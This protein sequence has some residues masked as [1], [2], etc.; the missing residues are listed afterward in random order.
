M[1]DSG[2]WDR[3]GPD[4]PPAG[5]PDQPRRSQPGWDEPGRQQPPGQPSGWEQPGW[6]QP[7][8]AGAPPGRPWEP[9]DTAPK[10]GT[11]PLRPLGI[12]ELLDGSLQA[13]RRNPRPMLLLPA[14]VGAVYGLATG[15]VLA[16]AAPTLFQGGLFDSGSGQLTEADASRL[17]LAVLGLL[18]VVILF[19]LA[20]L[21][22]TAV[23]T[24]VVAR[25]ALGDRTTA[26][27][28]WRFSRGRV[29]PLVGL[30]IVLGVAAAV[31]FSVGIALLVAL[32]VAIA[33][34]TT[35]AARVVLFVL[36]VLVALAAVVLFALVYVGRLGL[37]SVVL[38]LDG[39]FPDATGRP[40]GVFAAIAR[41]WRLTRGHLWRT[42]GV[43]LLVQLIAGVAAQLV[44]TPLSLLG[45]PLGLSDTAAQVGLP[46]LSAL[47]S[48]VG[49]VVALP[50]TA[51]GTTLTYLD[52]R[53]RREGLDLELALAADAAR[54]LQR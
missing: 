43:L 3:P 21:A 34:L 40:L 11:I 41:T 53:M 52:L 23:L 6:G 14:V 12:G 44:Q 31:A 32:G 16:V 37:A 1:S 24:V 45:G 50:F 15:I 49:L 5:G 17:G 51:A 9:A 4:G 2:G 27:E 54:G 38:V 20:T 48:V 18:P 39:R 7:G 29:L 46:I 33:E 25:S 19:G 26:G 13:I 22:V 30:G 35:G 47:T 28:A 10:P 36:L 42:L 8:P